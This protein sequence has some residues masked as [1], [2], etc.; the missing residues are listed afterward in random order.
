MEEFPFIFFKLSFLLKKE[1]ISG[2]RVLKSDFCTKKRKFEEKFLDHFSPYPFLLKLR[3]NYN[4]HS[5]L[6]K[7][8]KALLKFSPSQ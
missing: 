1:L 3:K 6:Q 8:G 5:H 4:Y 7:Y 2:E